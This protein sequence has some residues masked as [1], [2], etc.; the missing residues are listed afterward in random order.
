M[1]GALGAVTELS[2]SRSCIDE[3]DGNTADTLDYRRGELQ[4]ALC[5]SARGGKAGPQ[6]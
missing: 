3:G 1:V 6:A 2:L 5:L 4:A